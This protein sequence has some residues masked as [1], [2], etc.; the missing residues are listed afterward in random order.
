MERSMP[1]RP[2]FMGGRPGT[3]TWCRTLGGRAFEEELQPA[4]LSPVSPDQATP[5]ERQMAEALGL[6]DDDEWRRLPMEVGCC[7]WGGRCC[8][9]WLARAALEEVAGEPVGHLPLAAVVA[10]LRDQV[11]SYVDLRAWADSAE[12]ELQHSAIQKEEIDRLRRALAQ[13]Q[14]DVQELRGHAKVSHELQ[15]HH[16][17]LKD[18]YAK[19]KASEERM[20]EEANRIRAE[21]VLLMEG[22]LA[23]WR[24]RAENA[25]KEL[26]QLVQSREEH[27]ASS[28][29]LGRQLAVVQEELTNEQEKLLQ[30]KAQQEAKLRRRVRGQKTKQK[31]GTAGPKR[32]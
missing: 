29:N 24:L 26:V 30:Y 23:A 5:L 31:A 3:T 11:R 7:D 12:L 4:V 25:E 27:K 17:A 22:D 9:R 1:K 21:K 10:H 13:A 8:W 6:Q 14:E 18:D 20:R 2:A 16:A 15:E 28:K 32:R 19:M